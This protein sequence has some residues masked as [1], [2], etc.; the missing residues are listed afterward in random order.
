MPTALVEVQLR[1]RSYP[2]RIGSRL[3]G[4]P[5]TYRTLSPGSGAVIV[6]NRAVSGLYGGSLSA[7]L[8]ELYP[9]VDL[10]LVPDGE[11]FKT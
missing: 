9:R 10:V 2:I 1:E 7:A 5:T 3:L 4:E 8:G 11:A 6:S